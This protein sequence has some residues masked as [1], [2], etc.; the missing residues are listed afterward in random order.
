LKRRILHLIH[1]PRLSGAETLV[2]DLTMRQNEKVTFA[3]AAF[4][5]PEPAFEL[6]IGRLAESGVSLYFPDAS[7][8]RFERVRHFRTVYKEFK[9]HIIFGH[10]VLPAMYGRLALP[11]LGARP[12]FVSVL[13]SATNDDYSALSLRLSEMLLAR[14]A[15][16]VVA[17]SNEG[18]RMY[19]RRFPHARPVSVIPNGIDISRFRAV[20]MHRADHRRT[21]GLQPQDRMVLQIGRVSPVKQQVLTFD[22]LLPILR[23]EANVHLWFAGLTQDT[24]YAAELRAKIDK[25]GISDRVLMLGSRDDVPALLASA[26]L[27][28]MPSLQEAQSIAMLEALASGVAIVA[29]DIPA[30]QFARKHEGVHLVDKHADFDPSEICEIL[31]NAKRFDRAVHGLDIAQTS[32]SYLEVVSLV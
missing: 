16:Q 21:F 19:Q 25:S 23:T 17:V 22:S 29:S 26:D 32:T 6:S 5:P 11:L 7:L 4:N 14:R 24:N 18:A 2:R 9:P 1:T 30:F 8:I 28:V 20:S 13:H 15:D 10:S 27:Y 12:R 3:I 31:V